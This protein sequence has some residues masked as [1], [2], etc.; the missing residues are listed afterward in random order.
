ML[1]AVGLLAL[2]YTRAWPLTIDVGGRDARF[3]EAAR[4]DDLTYGF[5]ATENFNGMSVR[6]TTGDATIALPRPPDGTPARL[7]LRVLNSRPD[8]QPE[9][10]IALSVDGRSLGDYNVPP[11]IN[12]IRTYHVLLPGNAQLD[13]ATRLHIQSETITLPNDPRPLGVVVDQ[14]TLSVNG[15]PLPSL[16]LLMWS[17]ALGV[18]GYALPRSIGLGRGVS[19]AVAV[20]I[21]ALVSLGVASRP[22]EV[23]PFVQRIA[24]LLGVACVG[25]WVARLLAP[26]MTSAGGQGS[27]VRGQGSEDGGRTTN[28]GRRTTD[29]ERRTTDDE[30]RTTDHRPSTE[31]GRQPTTHGSRTTDYGL[32]TRGR[33]LPIYLAVAWWM[34]PLFQLV[35]TADGATNVT[36]SPATLWLGGITAIAVIVLVAW[37]AVLQLK[38]RRTTKD[39][40]RRTKDGRRTM[41]SPTH[42]GAEGAGA[43]R[44]AALHA[45]PLTVTPSSLHPFT[46]SPLHSLTRWALLIF[47][48][49]AL[50]H[51]VTM[52][53][54]AFTRT[55]PD[56]WILFKGAREWTRG[57]SL[58]DLNA[59]ITNHFGHVFKV[60]PFYGMLF[61]PFVTQ[62]GFRVLL[63]HR[64][65]NVILLAAAALIWLR[66]W[67]LRLVSV[68]GA[69]VLILLNFRPFA[70]T[71]AFGQIDLALLLI[72]TLALW[73]LRSERDVAAGVLIALGTLFKIY[74][75]LLLAFLIIKRSG[76][77]LLGFA[78]GM[79]LF[80]GAALAIMGWEMHRVYAFE[81]VPRIGGTTAWVENQ[82]ISGFITRLVS[83]P[84]DSGIFPDRTIALIATLISGAVAFGACVLSFR[85]TERKTTTFTLQYSQF[86]LLMVLVVPAAWMHYETL[87]FIPFAALLLDKRDQT[88]G[89]LWAAALAASFGLI[90]Y[91]NQWSFYDGT[92]MGVLTVAGVSYK[93]Y[94]MLLLGGLLAGR[95]L[96]EWAPLRDLRRALRWHSL[97]PQS[98]KDK[99][100]LK[101]R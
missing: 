61:T 73:A 3:V 51:L 57:G 92:V 78:L 54:F 47:A 16:F 59:V 29:D 42:P 66:M 84:R 26:V 96:N 44:G 22:L 31:G 13:W 10:R 69:G 12:G 19:L 14:V 82:T 4:P 55:G 18:L 85:P 35:M 53:Q 63:F 86:L 97:S 36:P 71:L 100:A 94:G 80:N 21:A 76:R 89:L 87:L 50:V 101:G 39:E 99:Q 40:G 1:F 75:V 45:P 65:L 6:W 7:S 72:L 93:F 83:S 70:D 32:Q 5:H 58:Y 17:A 37:C 95:L 98:H 52:L 74:P 27:G 9:P 81:V 2:A 77:G 8:G 28:D 56:F 46:P 62:D 11:P 24:A 33:D 49:I 91:G 43:Y 88:V 15:T 48:A 90:A 41:D 68:A 38:E 67:N 20:V 25:V 34:G 60:P 23:L 64:I 79:L 30:R